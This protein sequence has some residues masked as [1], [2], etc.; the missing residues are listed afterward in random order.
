M[1]GSDNVYI[2]LIFCIPMLKKSRW[3]IFFWGVLLLL[4]ITHAAPLLTISDSVTDS[5]NIIDVPDENQL[6]DIALRIKQATTSQI[7]IVTVPSLEGADIGVYAAQ[8]FEN[9]ELG[10]KGKDNGLLIIIA[11]KERR[12]R[13]QTGHGLKSVLPERTVRRIGM[14]ILEP[15]FR[16]GEFGDG[17]VQALDIIE[18]HLAGN[19]EIIS[20]FQNANSG[21]RPTQKNIPAEHITILTVLLIVF[22]MLFLCAAVVA[23]TI[24]KQKRT[25]EFS[26][27][28][29]RGFGR[30][31]SGNRFFEQF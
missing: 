6:R 31:F 20:H 24:H 26:G 27:Q 3:Y 21:I 5:A 28:Y 9:A 18:G 7:A 15:Y 1:Y 8:L 16:T 11:P 10:A 25:S 23:V 4:N 19:Q 22:F 12:Y 29:I 14:A 2:V 17:L 30:G 13:L